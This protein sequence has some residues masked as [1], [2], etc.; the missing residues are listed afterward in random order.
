M[1]SATDTTGLYTTSELATAV[2]LT[3]RRVQQLTGEGVLTKQSNGRYANEAIT[4]YVQYLRA[5]EQKRSKFADLIARERHRRLKR[6]NDEADARLATVEELQD[7]ADRITAEIA[8]ILRA[9]PA[10]IKQGLPELTAEGLDVVEDA[11]EKCCDILA[12]T[13]LDPDG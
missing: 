7:F 6:R 10:R 11:V 8:A 3:P 4:Q 12:D 2:G 5:R 13:D 1:T 9:L